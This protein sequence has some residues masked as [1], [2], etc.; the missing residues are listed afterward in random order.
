M[1]YFTA[2]NENGA[3]ERS[4]RIRIVAAAGVA[5][6]VMGAAACS[7]RRPARARGAARRPR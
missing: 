2:G 1:S 6:V 5:A 4:M 3:K 7:A